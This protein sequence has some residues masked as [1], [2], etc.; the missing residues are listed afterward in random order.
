MVILGR[1]YCSVPFLFCLLTR[2]FACLGDALV[3]GLL[4]L[5]N[6]RGSEASFYRQSFSHLPD[7]LLSNLVDVAHSRLGRHLT[8]FDTGS[9]CAYARAEGEWR[10]SVVS[11]NN[12]SCIFWNPCS[13]RYFPVSAC[14]A[15]IVPADIQITLCLPAV[16]CAP[17]QDALFEAAFDATR[18]CALL[19]LRALEESCCLE[20][21]D[22]IADRTRAPDALALQQI[23]LQ[24]LPVSLAGAVLVC[25]SGHFLHVTPAQSLRVITL[26]CEGT[27]VPGARCTLDLCRRPCQ[28]DS[29]S[30]VE[31]PRGPDWAL[32]LEQLASGACFRRHPAFPVRV[33]GGARNG[34]DW[35]NWQSGEDHLLRVRARACWDAARQLSAPEPDASMPASEHDNGGPQ[36][37]DEEDEEVARRTAVSLLHGTPGA[38]QRGL[39]HI[40]LL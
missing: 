22:S 26:I 6:N 38:V 29:A 23:R 13:C 8:L 16:A 20:V 37:S 3:V 1:K 15:P 9:N 12:G 14:S 35:A 39:P 24:S 32:P 30:P 11:P 17:S 27:E 5:F 33:V 34:G 18:F 40:T 10:Q 31:N 4:Q 25:S 28:L 7:W 21:S 2:L 19:R 36:P